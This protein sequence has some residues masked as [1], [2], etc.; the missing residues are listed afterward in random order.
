MNSE[1]EWVDGYDNTTYTDSQIFDIDKSTKEVAVISGQTLV[2]GEQLSQF[3]R[4]QMERYYDGVDLSTKEIQFIYMTE[5][6]YSDINRAVCVER[7]DEHIRFGWIIPEAASYDVGTTS[8]SIE[9]VGEDYVLKTRVADLEVYDGLNGGEI[10]PEPTEKVWYIELQQRC[11]TVLI[12]A[13]AAR[14]AAQTSATNAATSETNAQDAETLAK[15]HMNAAGES[16]TNAATSEA[17]A[18]TYAEQAASVF[19]I[20]GSTSFVV[21]ADNSVTMV[22][23]KS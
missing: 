6:G 15:A 21:N 20:A 17:Q 19:T 3:I 7:N 4:F 13:E 11:D 16:E 9:F 18:K 10:I 23:T 1:W 8:F 5:S 12:T 22:F 14:D 2:S